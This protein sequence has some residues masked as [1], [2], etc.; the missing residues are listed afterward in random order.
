[1]ERC[2]T[3]KKEEST[4]RYGEERFCLP[5][6]NTLMT[7]KLGVEATSYPEGVSIKDGLGEVHR[8]RLRKRLDPIGVI[9]EAEEQAEWKIRVPGKE[10]ILQNSDNSLQ[11]NAKVNPSPRT[12]GSRAWIFIVYTER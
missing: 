12:Q 7:E 9:M 11:M 5:C 2:Q 1:M 4:I 6:Y 10:T 3:C 8:Y